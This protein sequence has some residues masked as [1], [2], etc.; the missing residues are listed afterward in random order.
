MVEPAGFPQD[1]AH[2][3]GILIIS[4]VLLK[5]L[6]AGFASAHK[7]RSRPYVLFVIFDSIGDKK[8]CSICSTYVFQSLFASLK[9][10]IFPMVDLAIL[11]S[12]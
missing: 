7:F 10:S 11:L 8:N 12:S 4:T 6:L 9:A 5:D 2:L 3:Y 1:E